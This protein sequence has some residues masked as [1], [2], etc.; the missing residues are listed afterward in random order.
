M[1][2]SLN[3]RWARTIVLFLAL[4]AAPAI[5]M[6]TA[7][8]ADSLHVVTASDGARL[9][10][11]TS[12]HAGLSVRQTFDDV[13]K[14]AAADGYVIAIE[15]DYSSPNP[16]MGI[17]KPPSPVP[18]LVQVQQPSGI[19]FTSI[20]PPGNA[21]KG[22][23]ERL[24]AMVG[25]FEAGRP[26]VPNQFEPAMTA[27]TLEQSRTTIPVTKPV[28]NILKPDVPFDL[29]AAKAALEPGRSTI[30][31]QVCGSWRGNLVLGSQPVLLYPVTPYLQQI[32]A[33]GKKAKRGKDQV[34]TDPDL[35]V[36][37]M[38]AKP[39]EN[40]EFQFSRMKLGEY[41]LVTSISAVLGGSRDVYAGH[42][43]TDYGSGNVYTSQNFSFG[44]DAGI[45]R[46]VEVKKDGDTVKVTMQPH[47]SAFNHSG[48][49][50]SIL[51]C[52]KFGKEVSRG[53]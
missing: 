10:T 25:K 18:T 46:I 32:L 43:D 4:M 47:I 15:P 48:L 45:E 9:F 35:V 2:I 30:R 41:Y 44:S 7:L 14:I 16:S 13:R 42:V 53:M 17:G 27:E 50:G 24:C 29:A 51:G 39:N 38:E 49:S 12:T 1:I 3:K 37:R 19:S 11:A 31:G 5:G 40:G 33:L 8:C 52:S 20:V 6:A 28:V 34:V 26:A 22:V 23:P 36:A 21:S